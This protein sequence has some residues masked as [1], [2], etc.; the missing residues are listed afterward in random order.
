M[1]VNKRGVNSVGGDQR[2]GPVGDADPG[3]DRGQDVGQFLAADDSLNWLV[4]A[5]IGV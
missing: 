5:T 1:S 2:D 4:G 3:D